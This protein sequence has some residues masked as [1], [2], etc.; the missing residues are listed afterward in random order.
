[1]L[2]LMADIQLLHQIELGALFAVAHVSVTDQIIDR[3]A[4]GIESGALENTGKKSSAPVLRMAFGN[5][6]AQRVVHDDEGGKVLID[7]AET[8]GDPGAHAGE[9]HPAH[10]G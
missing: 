2:L 6:A 1:M 5:T 8:V 3:R 10:P 4:L 7:R 9:T